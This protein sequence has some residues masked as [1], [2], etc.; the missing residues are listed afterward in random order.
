MRPISSTSQKKI[1]MQ[2]IHSRRQLLRF[3]TL[4][5]GAAC[6]GSLAQAC[7]SAPPSAP[8]ATS[9]LASVPT[10]QP[11]PVP[12]AAPPT[13]APAVGTGALPKLVVSYGA[14]ASS[15]APFWMAKATGAFEKYGLSV[16]MQFIEGLAAVPA[17]I[18][19]DTDVQE[20]GFAQI[21]PADVN[22][23]QDLVM[24]AS[25]L[26]HLASALYAIS[27]IASSEQLK[28]KVIGSDKPGTTSDYVVRQ[29]LSLLGLK[30]EE[31]EIR[32]IGTAPEIATAMLSGQVQAGIV[33]PP[34]SFQL[35]TRG[36][37]LLR[38]IFSQPYQ[39]IGLVARR[40]RLDVL[41]PALRPLVSAF[42]DGILAW[43]NQPELAMNVLDQY[44]QMGDA[45][46]LRKSYEF[47]TRVTPFEPSLQPTIPGMKAILDF[48]AATTVPAAAQFTPEQ[49][50]DGRFLAQLP[51]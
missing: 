23:N 4:T 30:P 49:F 22:G 28:G 43:N 11:K 19:N 40:S 15:Y 8:T 26:N 7:V 32:A 50:V 34:Q 10:A 33:S 39:S 46:I 25:G 29:S 44:T 27:E 3:A 47:F 21:V 14:R 42:R 16:D 35:E 24:I 13:A 9:G 2:T 17:M 1:E 38:D 12:T 18:A 31:V 45:E 41:A 20:S 48:L 51:S 5:F 37:R 36:F 6:A